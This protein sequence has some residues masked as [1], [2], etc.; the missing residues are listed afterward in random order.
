MSNENFDDFDTHEHSD[1][2]IP[3]HFDER[4]DWR[5]SRNDEP[6]IHELEDQLE[7]GDWGEDEPEELEELEGDWEAI[8]DSERDGYGWDDPLDGCY[9]DD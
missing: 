2:M 9:D 6:T 8:A 7:D 3:D 1:E 4:E 5:D